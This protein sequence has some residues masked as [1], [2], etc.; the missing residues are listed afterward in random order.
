MFVIMFMC[1]KQIMC[2][3]MYA[4]DSMNWLI[5]DIVC[6]QLIRS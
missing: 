2:A 5:R 3:H 4:S 6:V 1:E